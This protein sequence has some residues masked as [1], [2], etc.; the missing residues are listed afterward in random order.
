MNAIYKKIEIDLYSPNSYEIIKAQQGDSNSRII[1]FALYNQGTPYE[2]TE[3][4]SCKFMGHRGNGSSFLKEDCIS[5]N[6]NCIFV[7]LTDDILFYPGTIEAKI[8]LYDSSNDFVLSTVP[9]RILCMKSPCDENN[10]SNGE[11]SIITDLI[12]Q[13]QEFSKSASEII[14]QAKSSADLAASKADEATL[15]ANLAVLSSEAAKS[16]EENAEIY[17][18]DASNSASDAEKNAKLAIEKSTEAENSAKTARSYT[19]GD[20]FLRENEEVD[21]AKYYYT[22]SKKIYENFANSSDVTGVKGNEEEDYRSGFVNIT[23]EDIGAI[24]KYGGELNGNI[25][26]IP[27]DSPEEEHGIGFLFENID[28]SIW[29][30]IS[31]VASGNSFYGLCLSANTASPWTPSNGLYITM[32][33]SI[34]WKGSKLLTELTG[35]LKTDSAL[36]SGANAGTV[37]STAIGCGANAYGETSSSFGYFAKAL[38]VN[39]TAIGSGAFS[40]AR[41]TALGCDAKAMDDSTAIGLNANATANHSTAVGY[42]SNA[43]GIYSTAL[44]YRTNCSM[45]ANYSTALGYCAS[46]ANANSIQLGN[47]S[48]LSSITSKVAITVTSDERDKF[49]VENVSEGAVEF[50]KRIRAVTYVFNGRELYIDDESKLSDSDKEKKMKYGLCAYDKAAHSSGTKKGKRRRI[51]VLAQ[52]VQ[53]ALESTFGNSSYANLVNNNL[54]DFNEEDVPEDVESQLAVNYEGFIPFL[55]KAVQELDERI[56]ALERGGQ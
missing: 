10:L 44:G 55:I 2:L 54:F 18:D 23:P 27:S 43:K 33:N 35:A 31:A 25:E 15:K 53:Q 24:S 21:N 16:S 28:K 38:G 32:N 4:I 41:S 42:L 9:F 5:K 6:E 8:V 39:A 7:T 37:S 34:Y 17:K 14:K 36:G 40:E 29:G 52:E 49:D 13:V 19:E 48:R 30:G 50:L 26:I 45:Y 1:E 51:G 22:Q 12:F 3:N 47:A 46:T 20:T 11:K 56:G